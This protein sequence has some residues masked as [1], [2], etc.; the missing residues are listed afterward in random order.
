[1]AEIS[2]CI[3]FCHIDPVRPFQ[4]RSVRFVEGNIKSGWLN[5]DLRARIAYH[6][7][8]AQA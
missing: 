3:P 6:F 1:M 5:W 4:I 8:G 7:V 2:L